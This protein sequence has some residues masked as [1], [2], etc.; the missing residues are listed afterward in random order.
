MNIKTVKSTENG[1]LING[2]IHLSNDSSGHVQSAYQDWLALGNT[3]AHEFTEYELLAV[4]TKKELDLAK[5]YVQEQ[6]YVVTVNI[7]YHTDNNPRK[8]ATEQQWREYRVALCDYVQRGENGDYRVIGDKPS[9][10]VQP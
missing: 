3:P 6:M 10:P 4:K 5:E 7:G 1:V 9:Q 2:S 8:S